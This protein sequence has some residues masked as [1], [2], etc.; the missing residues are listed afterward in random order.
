MGDHVIPSAMGEFRGAAQFLRICRSCNSR[1]GAFEQ[2]LIQTSP[3]GYLSKSF[4]PLSKRAA[5]RSRGAKSRA[6]FFVK[7]GDHLQLVRPVTGSMDDASPLDQVVILDQNGNQDVVRLYPEMTISGFQKK[8]GSLKLGA[9]KSARLHCNENHHAQYLELLRGI[10]PN[11]NASEGESTPAGR[12]IRDGTI[13]FTVTN[14]CFRAIAQIAFHYW[15]LHSSRRFTGSELLFSGIRSYILGDGGMEHHF[16]PPSRRFEPGFGQLEGGGTILPSEWC[17]VLAADESEGSIVVC[18]RLFCGPSN[19]PKPYYVTIADI[20]RNLI[21]RPGVFAHMYVLEPSEVS[22]KFS[23]YVQ[24][25]SV[26]K[27][28]FWDPRLRIKRSLSWNEALASAR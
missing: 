28:A 8:L 6:M 5:K 10:W 23:G 13:E 20:H 22:G 26:S 7:E 16:R 18:I 15:L 9:L 1:I 27:S 25:V 24:E 11:F 3:E 4:P 14:N 19:L 17:H 2:E 12:H 21:L